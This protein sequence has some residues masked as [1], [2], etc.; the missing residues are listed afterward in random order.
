MKIYYYA[1]AATTNFLRSQTVRYAR[2]AGT[3]GRRARSIAA[4]LRTGWTSARFFQVDH[5]SRSFRMDQLWRFGKPSERA[6]TRYNDRMAREKGRKL[7]CLRPFV[8]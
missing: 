3:P 1:A 8:G 2:P 7:K 6:A 5:L 4:L